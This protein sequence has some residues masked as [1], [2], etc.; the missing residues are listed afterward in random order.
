MPNYQIGAGQPPAPYS[1]MN[2]THS[3]QGNA[4]VLPQIQD[5]V[6]GPSTSVESLERAC[7]DGSS[8]NFRKCNSKTCL[9]SKTFF[10]PTDKM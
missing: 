6:G 5:F 2:S 9:L 10:K 3:L 7:G 8:T 4:D 1:N